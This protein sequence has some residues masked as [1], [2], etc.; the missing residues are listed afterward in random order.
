MGGQNRP[1]YAI[2][3]FKLGWRIGLKADF[4]DMHG[5][6][7]KIFEISN[8]FENTSIFAIFTAVQPPN[9]KLTF[10]LQMRSFFKF[11]IPGLGAEVPKK[12]VG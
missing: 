12:K 1:K 9:A 7:K 11:N 10:K 2:L 5:F 8:V 4:D 6:R 3:I